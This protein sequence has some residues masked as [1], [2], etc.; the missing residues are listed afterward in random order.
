M[1][2]CSFLEKEYAINPSYELMTQLI[3][4]GSE[5]AIKKY[6]EIVVSSRNTPEKKSCSFS[7]TAAIAIIK[8]TKFY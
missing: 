7:G 3:K 6:V 4:L 1:V 5:V 8:D 2:S